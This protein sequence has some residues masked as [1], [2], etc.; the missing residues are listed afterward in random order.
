M[1]AVEEL[2]AAAD[3]LRVE[4]WGPSIEFEEALADWLDDR[5]ATLRVYGYRD[6]TPENEPALRLARIINGEEE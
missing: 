3:A 1:N 4:K 6:R 2:S 5:A